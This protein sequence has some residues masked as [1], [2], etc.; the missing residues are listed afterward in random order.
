MFHSIKKRLY[1]KFV[2]SNLY[3]YR[4][5]RW[6]AS[7][8][9]DELAKHRWKH[10]FVLLKLNWDYQYH[11]KF[12]KLQYPESSAKDYPPVREY[13]TELS[14]YDVISFDIFDTLLFRAVE[15]PR[16]IFDILGVEEKFTAFGDIRR[17]AEFEARKLTEKPNGEINIYDIYAH[18][19]KQIGINGKEWAEKEI[20][21]EFEF[22]FA[23]PFMKEIYDELLVRE[24]TLVASSDMYLPKEVLITL[25]EKNGYTR[26]AD[27]F[28]SCECGV[29]KKEGELQKYISHYLGPEKKLVFVGDN[30]QKDIKATKKAGFAA[31]YYKNVSQCGLPYRNNIGT[32]LSSSVCKGILNTYLHNGLEPMDPH[33]EYGF[34]YGGMLVCGYCEWLNRFAK[35]QGID[36]FLFMS[37]DCDI[38][39][40]V[41]EKYYNEVEHEYV[42]T[43]RIAL[44]PTVFDR[45]IKRF[46]THAIYPRR[47][48]NGTGRTIEQAFQETGIDILIE[49]IPEYGLTP[50]TFLTKS[51]YSIVKRMIYDNKQLLLDWFKSQH[52]AAIEY[53]RPIIAGH[54]KVC[55][56]DVGWNGNC[57]MM[58][59]HLCQ[60]FVDPSVEVV[61]TML[62]SN[63]TD[64][65]RLS[66][67]GSGLYTYLFSPHENDD[68]ARRHKGNV[69]NLPLEFMFTAAQPGLQKYDFDSEE[70]VIFQFGEDKPMD[71]VITEKIQKGILM[72][73]EIYNRF[74]INH[75][76]V[77]VISPYDALGQFMPVQENIIFLS[78]LF[79]D[80]GEEALPGKNVTNSRNTFGELLM[81]EGLMK[82]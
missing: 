76:D 47:G 69:F 13:I 65:T 79:R 23:N 68:L 45:D 29:N 41:Y 21:L 82:H 31:I 80:Y 75:K 4:E 44:M 58:L 8:H 12:Q 38:I 81:N 27:V 66:I 34:A 2:K 42:Y 26:F 72:F 54:N 71:Y 77:C 64:E 28:V 15:N 70:R 32:G 7:S 67:S 36:K 49:K 43:S 3:I 51:T 11:N 40:K 74:T 10:W 46:I 37:R 19:E 24:K 61:G 22:C 30:L 55:A 50:G 9:G 63:R 59:Q 25:L 56:V 39:Q 33:I 20:K 6:Y 5:Y 14:K 17:T 78:S 52:D 60:T 18:L 1:D 16:D 35:A 73:A 53:F 62:G 57:F 48:K